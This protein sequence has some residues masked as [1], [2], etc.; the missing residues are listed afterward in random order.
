M[1]CN[2]KDR[3]RRSIAERWKRVEAGELIVHDVPGSI[4]ASDELSN[5]E[6]KTLA[7]MELLLPAIPTQDLMAELDRRKLEQIDPCKASYP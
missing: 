5:A 6:R 2:P 3:D 7:Q 4:M 1:A